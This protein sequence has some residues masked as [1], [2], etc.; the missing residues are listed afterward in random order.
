M[1]FAK[2]LTNEAVIE[3]LYDPFETEVDPNTTEQ[4]YADSLR[5]RLCSDIEWLKNNYKDIT[6]IV[7][8][9]DKILIIVSDRDDLSDFDRVQRLLICR[10]TSAMGF[11]HVRFS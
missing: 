4:E 6:K 10:V 8:D 7:N 5:E 11:R 1:E 2:G 9:L 3:G